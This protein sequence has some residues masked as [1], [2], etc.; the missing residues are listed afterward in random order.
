MTTD[1]SRNSKAALRFAIQLASQYEVQLV[2]FNTLELLIPTRWN[3]VK[4]KIHMD[5]ELAAETEQLKKFVMKVYREMG[6]KAGQYDCVVRYGA[7]VSESI[8][9]YA[10]EIDA[11]FICIATR[12]AGALKKLIGTHTSAVIKNSSIPVFAIPKSYKTSIIK[13]FLYA[14]DLSALKEEFSIVKSF[15]TKLECEIAVVHYS[16]NPEALREPTRKSHQF[17]LRVEKLREGEAISKH[18]KRTARKV[19]ADVV[20]LFSDQDKSWFERLLKRSNSEDTSLESSKPVL[21][22]PKK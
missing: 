11:S 22:Y 17:N 20:A 19:K 6:K 18:L 9:E 2:F 14:S 16:Q 1:L 5:E 4:A 13:S 10:A 15:A 7:P 3:E 21:V 12:G 8:L